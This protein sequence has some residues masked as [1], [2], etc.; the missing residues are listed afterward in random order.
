MMIEITSQE[1]SRIEELLGEM[2]LEEKCAQLGG[3]RGGALLDE[4]RELSHEKLQSEL[5][6]GIGQV[7]RFVCPKGIAPANCCDRLECR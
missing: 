3:V 1:Q 2:T 6:F 5:E 4:D 7:A